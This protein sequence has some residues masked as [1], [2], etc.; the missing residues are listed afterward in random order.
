MVDLNHTKSPKMAIK[1]LKKVGLKL[2][3][4]WFTF[5]QKLAKFGSNVAHIWGLNGVQI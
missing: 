5:A 2:V 4:M 3:E 1:V